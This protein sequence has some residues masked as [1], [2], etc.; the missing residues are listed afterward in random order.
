M[1][2]TA[3]KWQLE[4]YDSWGAWVRSKHLLLT[5]VQGHQVA[6]A[7]DAELGAYDSAVAQGVQ[8]KTTRLKDS[9]AAIRAAQVTQVGNP[10]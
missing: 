8:P 7:W 6:K 10:W 3:E 4:G 5:P 1:T 2:V 9:Q